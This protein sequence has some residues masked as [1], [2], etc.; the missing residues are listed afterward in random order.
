MKLFDVG[1][2]ISALMGHGFR[3]PFKKY[4]KERRSRS[5]RQGAET[6]NEINLDSTALLDYPLHHYFIWSILARRYKIA[7]FLLQK[8]AHPMAASLIA[9][10]LLRRLTKQAKRVAATDISLQFATESK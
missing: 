3:N 8:V 4:K 2:I 9:Y 10:T 5:I 1:S 6:I 7:H